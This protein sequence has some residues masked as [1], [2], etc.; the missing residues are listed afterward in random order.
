MQLEHAQLLLQKN[1]VAFVSKE[2]NQV[3]V[4]KTYNILKIHNYLSFGANFV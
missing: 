3:F 1:N 2:S 4:K